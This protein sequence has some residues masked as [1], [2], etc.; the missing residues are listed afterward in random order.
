MGVRGGVSHRRRA[1]L[2][3][4]RPRRTM[5]YRKNGEFPM[6]TVFAALLCAATALPFSTPLRAE[7]INMATI[8]CKDLLEG[9]AEDIGAILMWLH[10]YYGG[11]ANDTRLDTD[12]FT[13]GSEQIGKYCGQNP[14]V[15]M[16][17]AIERIFK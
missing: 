7:V 4:E 5:G 16:M 1:W 12:A 9:K 6:R 17:Q 15:T 2:P 8:T 3:N 14:T 13:K 10:G 11:R